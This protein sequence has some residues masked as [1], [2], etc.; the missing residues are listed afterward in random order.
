MTTSDQLY[1]SV[2]PAR[3]MTVPTSCTSCRRSQV[4]SRNHGKTHITQRRIKYFEASSHNSCNE[5][6]ER[7]KLWARTRI[8]KQTNYDNQN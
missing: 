4:K 7:S 5:K 8:S 2:K 1:Q 3:F 6:K